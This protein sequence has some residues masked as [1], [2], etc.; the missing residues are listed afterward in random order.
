MGN[1]KQPG[2]LLS[3]LK[4]QLLKQRESAKYFNRDF[5]ARFVACYNDSKRTGTANYSRVFETDFYK[6]NGGAYCVFLEIWNEYRR[7]VDRFN[8]IREA[9]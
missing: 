9:L 7:G 4:S 3:Y 8:K 1:R 2:T 6:K 5:L